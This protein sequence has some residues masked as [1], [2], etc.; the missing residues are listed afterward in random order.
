MSRKHQSSHSHPPLR[1]SDSP[2][3]I[4]RVSLRGPFVL[5]RQKLHMVRAPNRSTY[6]RGT[7]AERGGSLARYDPILLVPIRAGEWVH[8]H[9]TSQTRRREEAGKQATG[10]RRRR[11]DGRAGS[12]QQPNTAYP[13]WHTYQQQSRSVLVHT[14]PQPSPFL[15]NPTSLPLNHERPIANLGIQGYPPLEERNPCEATRTPSKQGA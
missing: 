9:A 4:G 13:S 11:W 7:E 8:R 3:L 12:E 1:S 14:H 10:G 5:Q 15:L 6:F 2:D